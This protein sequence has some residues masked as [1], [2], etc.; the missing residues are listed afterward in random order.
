MNGTRILG[1]WESD[2]L[3]ESIPKRHLQTIYDVA[4]WSGM[5]YV[6]IQRFWEHP[7]WWLPG[8]KAIH[9]PE[10]AVKK[11]KRKQRERYIH[12]AP[13][14]L[15]NVL[16]YFHTN[17]KPPSLQAWNENLLRWAENSGLN[18]MGLSAKS[19]RKSIES[20]MISS[21]MPLHVVCLRQGHDSLTSMRHYQGL[22]FTEDER[23]EIRR[24][25]AGWAY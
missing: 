18:S 16:G 19:T 9:L 11:A 7:E 10:E 24:R 8:R 22:P 14:Q 6:E 2:T 3:R 23:A 17:P 15:E 5:R 21:G 12:P 20:W 13:P 1:P 25:L 4:L